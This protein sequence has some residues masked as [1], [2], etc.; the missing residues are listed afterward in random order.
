MTGS[1]H[2]KLHSWTAQ[3]SAACGMSTARFAT[4]SICHHSCWNFCDGGSNALV[5]QRPN[6]FGLHDFGLARGCSC[7][8]GP[9]GLLL[10]ADSGLAR[11]AQANQIP[12]PTG[13]HENTPAKAQCSRIGKSLGEIGTE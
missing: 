7:L 10:V 4:I 6:Q 9:A 8:E 5:T 12:G 11:P 2:P 13:G 1:F 3:P